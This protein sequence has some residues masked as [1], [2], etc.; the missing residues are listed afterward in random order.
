MI[1]KLFNL[2][3]LERLEKR[4]KRF[5][6][7]SPNQIGFKKGHR[8]SDHMFVLNSIVN[9]IVRKEK[10]KL[11]VAFIDFRKAFDRV[12]RKL[13]LLKLQRLGIKGLLYRNIKEMYRSISYLVKV[14]GGHLEAIKSLVGLKQGCVLSRIFFNL[15]IDDIRYIFDESCDPVKSLPFLIFCMQMTSCYYPHQK[16][17]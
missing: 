14:D 7:L 11:F 6:T 9:K 17:V 1:S 8:T 10:G 12:N 15:Y 5:Y 16:M 13:I 3:I 4:I 2:I